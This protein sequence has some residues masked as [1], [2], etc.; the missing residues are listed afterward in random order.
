MQ[1]TTAITILENKSLVF[2]NNFVIAVTLLHFAFLGSL[3]YFRKCQKLPNQGK[4]KCEVAPIF[5]RLIK[6]SKKAG[7][8]N[9]TRIEITSQ[10]VVLNF[11]A[12]W[13]G[14]VIGGWLIRMYKYWRL[15]EER[16]TKGTKSNCFEQKRKDQHGQ[17]MDIDSDV[18]ELLVCL[19]S[20]RSVRIMEASLCEHKQ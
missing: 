8:Y 7:F 5:G 18:F 9:V 16:K 15:G 11:I 1:E 17:L 20:V 13:D 14:E 12:W 10:R 6:T 3:T 4:V 19:S 2:A